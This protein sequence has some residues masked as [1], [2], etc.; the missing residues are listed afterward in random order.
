MIINFFLWDNLKFDVDGIE[1]V[2]CKFFGMLYN[3]YFFFV[4]YVNVDGFEYKEVDF[5]M[6]ECLEID[7]WILFVLNI[8]VKE[9]DICY[10]EYELIKVGCLIL[11]FVNDNLF[12][13]YVC[14][15]CKCFWGGGFI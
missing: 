9:V 11:D 2:C 8:L 10:N 4:L 6:N 5:L 14:L 13:W 12:N 1:E 3:I 7:W 15:N